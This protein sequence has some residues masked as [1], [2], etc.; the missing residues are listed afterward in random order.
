MTRTKNFKISLFGV[1]YIFYSVVRSL[2]GDLVLSLFCRSGDKKTADIRRLRPGLERECSKVH[3]SMP[4]CNDQLTSN[5]TTE[6]K[7]SM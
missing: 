7:Y 6:K 4:D 5:G 3:D 1:R 2:T